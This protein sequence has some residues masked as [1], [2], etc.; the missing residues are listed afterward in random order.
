MLFVT[1]SRCSERAGVDEAG[2]QSG[3]SSRYREVRHQ[4]QG[5]EHGLDLSGKMQGNLGST[6]YNKGLFLHYRRS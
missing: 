3:G 5:H 1:Q 6:H 2:G 4:G